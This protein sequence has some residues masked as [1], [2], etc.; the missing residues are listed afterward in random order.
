MLDYRVKTFIKVCETLNFTKAAQDLH[1]TQPAVTKHI[2]ALEAE[3]ACSLFLFK[4]KQCQMTAEGQKLFLMLTSMTNDIKH[5]KQRVHE[6]ITQLH[7]GAT[8]TI[9]EYVLTESLA[10]LMISHP[11]LELKMSIANTQ[12]L[13]GEID[14]GEIDFAVIEGFFSQEQYDSSIYKHEPFIAVA[15]PACPLENQKLGLTDLLAEPLIIREEGSG[16]REVLDTILKEKNLAKSDFQKVSEISNLNTIKQ[17][18]SRNLRI[19]FFYRSV[20]QK[21]LEKGGLIELKLEEFPVYHDFTFVWNKNSFFEEEYKE[22]LDLIRT[23]A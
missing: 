11:R 12:K 9:G 13:L 22:V 10:Q 3:Y 16:T 14:R 20:V 5:F 23:Y 15:S 19:S 7:F 21:E 4:G 18:V 1:I 17:L 2:K 6:T 8:M